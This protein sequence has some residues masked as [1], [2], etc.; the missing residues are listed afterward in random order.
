MAN[1]PTRLRKIDETIPEA[2]DQLVSRCVQPDAAARFQTT[3]ELVAALNRL[4]GRG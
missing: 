1:E 2:V 3:A 4:D